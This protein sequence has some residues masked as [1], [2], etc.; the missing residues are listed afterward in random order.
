MSETEKVEP[1]LTMCPDCDGPTTPV[2]VH[3][4][5]PRWLAKCVSRCSEPAPPT[6]A[7]ADRI[8]GWVYGDPKRPMFCAE[9]YE[10]VHWGMDP[11]ALGEGIRRATLIVTP[12]TQDQPCAHHPLPPVPGGEQT[13]VCEHCGVVMEQG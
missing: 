9:G 12:L 13:V 2:Y 1:K 4:D 3:G 11:L 7:L 5:N 10:P 8:E 6:D